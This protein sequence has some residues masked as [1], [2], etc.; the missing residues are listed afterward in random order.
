M[1]ICVNNTFYY[2]YLTY[3]RFL[4]NAT[5]LDEDVITELDRIVDDFKKEHPEI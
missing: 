1:L 5:K 2:Y 4:R 3:V